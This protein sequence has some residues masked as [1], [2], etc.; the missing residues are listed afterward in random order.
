MLIF[1]K[2]LS[3]DNI[4]SHLVHLYQLAKIDSNVV[5]QEK[6]YLFELA[7]KNGVTEQAVKTILLEAED[8]P[9]VLP[10]GR[11]E[12]IIFMYEYIQMMLVD[13]KLDERE[14]R[15]CTIIAEKMGFNSSV[16]RGIT[17][18]IVLAYDEN[19]YPVL[20]NN[21]LNLFLNINTY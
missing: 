14:A 2:K 9:F 17:N 16:V 20:S 6:E 21:E 4:K 12:R 7:E 13:N 18:A 10:N 3:F 1:P 19:C 15:M 11:E 8:H 5:N